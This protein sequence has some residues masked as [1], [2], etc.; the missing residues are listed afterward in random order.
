MALGLGLTIPDVA[1]RSNAAGG[2][3]LPSSYAQSLDFTT[4]TYWRDGTQYAAISSMPGH[5]FTRTGT[6]LALDSDTTIDSFAANVPA[7]N[8]RGYHAYAALT[9]LLLNAGQNTVLVTQSPTVTAVAHTIA[10]I[11]TGTVTLSGAALLTGATLAG[12]SATNQV[13]L[14]FTPTA[15]GALTVTVTGDV[16]YAV[17][18]AASLAVPVPI[19]ST[20][21]AAAGIGASDLEVAAA[22]PAGDFIAWVALEMN[23]LP[24]FTA[25]PISYSTAGA[26][27]AAERLYLTV[28]TGGSLGM[29][30]TT[31]GVAQPVG[32]AIASVITSTGGRFAALV[33]Y[34]G[35]IYSLAAKKA[36]GAIIIG[37]D[38]T[39]AATLPAATA[40]ELAALYNGGA[41]I[42]GQL[43]GAFQRNG[44]FSDADI[45]AILT[46][47]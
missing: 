8:G 38:A 9:N 32:A 18:M 7:I 13:G 35:G 28:N 15:G 34:R 22:L 25:A 20:A 44:T 5:A 4:G 23:R 41:Q 29:V 45:T 31:A 40:L 39:G 12:T 33:R 24:P 3:A 17:L 47:A 30:A 11:G 37:A 19:I 16:R 6:Q 1:I 2:V 21:G 43:E 26:G 10:F 36:D 46:A 14:N 27:S 42:Y